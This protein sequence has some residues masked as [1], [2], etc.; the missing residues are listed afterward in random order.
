MTTEKAFFLDVGAAKD[1]GTG[2]FVG[3]VLIAPFAT[4]EEAEHAA[5]VCRDVLAPSLLKISDQVR[6]QT[7]SGLV[8]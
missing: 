6:N 7:G 5:R 3:V 4:R 8:Q 2:G 1:T